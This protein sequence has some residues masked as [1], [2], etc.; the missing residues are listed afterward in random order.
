MR[1]FWYR[2]SEI[3]KRLS[4]GGFEVASNLD[5]LVSHEQVRILYLRGV[6]SFVL[7]VVAIA[8]VALWFADDL[9]FSKF[10]MWWLALVV[11]TSFDL[12]GYALFR[13]KNPTELESRS[14]YYTYIAC[15]ATFSV[16]W[17]MAVIE[18]M[19]LVPPQSSYACLLVLAGVAGVGVSEVGIRRSSSAVYLAGLFLPASA[20]LLWRGA[21]ND[22]G[23]AL[24]LLGYGAAL[25]IGGRRMAENI[26]S[27]LRLQFENQELANSLKRSNSR[28]QQANQEL[29]HA[30]STD[31]LT[32]VAN[33]RYFEQ[34]LEGEWQRLAREDGD[35]S[36]LMIDVDHFKHFNDVQGHPAGD[37]ALVAVAE[38]LKSALRRPA[39]VLARYGGEEFIVLLPNTSRS[40]GMRVAQ[41]M[42][43]RVELLELEHPGLDGRDIVTVS[44]GG[45]HSIVK[46]D[47]ASRTLIS[48]A[49]KALYAAKKNGRN[50]VEMAA[51][52][53]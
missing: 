16:V 6:T 23:A 49:D 22:T 37:Q 2:R 29:K 12:V 38:A 17:S 5:Q 43:E 27:S 7:E 52:V 51:P 24:F 11:V 35:L 25:W 4:S 36:V 47:D 8:F 46:A 26:T 48:T 10:K 18:M 34:H 44:V 15:C 33:R 32:Q 21:P 45:A 39:D 1:A 40:G 53:D 30:S 42:R 50:R 19:S 31:P 9:S 20:W 3:I 41:M 28:L 13:L 14:W